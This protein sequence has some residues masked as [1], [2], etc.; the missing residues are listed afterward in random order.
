M[1]KEL[2]ESKI[3]VVPDDPKDQEVAKQ[4]TQLIQWHNQIET[5]ETFEPSSELVLPE[6]NEFKFQGT[7]E[8]F[9]RHLPELY[10][11]MMKE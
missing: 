7:M 6:T 9:K 4:M 3:E 8:E 1:L 5:P 2:P 11:K 10:E